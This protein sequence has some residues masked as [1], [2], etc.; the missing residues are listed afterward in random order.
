MG[1]RCRKSSNIYIVVN[2][3]EIMPRLEMIDD[4]RSIYTNEYLL[5]IAIEQRERV[6]EWFRDGRIYFK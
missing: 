5:E 1:S 6:K 2:G 3:N 4:T